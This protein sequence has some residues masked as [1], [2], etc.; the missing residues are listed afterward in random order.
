M[1]HDSVQLIDFKHLLWISFSIGFV[2]LCYYIVIDLA[3]VHA[4]ILYCLLD[5]DPAS[6]SG[7]ALVPPIIWKV[8]VL[9]WDHGLVIS[10]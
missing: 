7:V 5:Y 2:Y 8:L 4:S 6:S 10:D 1:Y 3:L 9:P